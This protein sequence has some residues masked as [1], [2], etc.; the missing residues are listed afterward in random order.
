MTGEAVRRWWILGAMGTILGVILLDETAVGVALPQLQIELAIDEVTSHWVISAYILVLTGLAAAAGRFGDIVGHRLLMVAGLLLFGLSSLACGLAQS[1]GWLIAARAVQGAGAAVIFPAS[2]AMVTIAFP[3]R[4]RGFALGVYGA[5]GTTFLAAGPLVGGVLTD[6]LS[7]RWIFWV[8]PPIVLAVAL[9]VELAWRD[10]PREGAAPDLDRNGLVLLVSGLSLAI[11]AI[12]EGPERGWGNPWILVA[13][14]LGCVMLLAFVRVERRVPQPLIEV[15][16]FADRS[17]AA[18]NLVLFVTQYSKMAVFV[19][20]A[21]YLQDEM[22]LSPLMAGV[23]LLPAVA[24]QIATA[25]LAGRAADRYGARWPTI[26]GLA[27]LAAGLGLIGIAVGPGSYAVMFLG[28]LAN[29]L[30]TAF[31]FVPPQR[32]IMNAV[33]PAKQGQAGGIAMTAQL[34]GGTV[35]MAV[36]STL[37]SMTG[38]FRVVFLAAAAVLT[39]ALAV[40]FAA[41]ERPTAAEPA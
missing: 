14:V 40:G 9:I 35:G 17:F 24:P 38:D 8:N 21:M 32:A 10:P 1:G 20:G 18:C 36:C 31:L 25:M 26:I 30:A 11:F 22:K 23:A 34:L 7:W 27:A 4:Q 28:L 16:L 6:L 39:A 2:L 29:G 13:L 15:D 12:M 19:F 33:P 41:I 3:E 37:F 5:I